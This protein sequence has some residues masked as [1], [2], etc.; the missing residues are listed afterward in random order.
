MNLL[1]KRATEH[2]AHAIA[3]VSCLSWQSAYKDIIPPAELARHTNTEARTRLFERLISSGV[4]NFLL[5]LDDTIPCGMCSY[6]S[7]RDADMTGWGEIVAIYTTEAYWGKGV[8]RAL[9]NAAIAGLRKLGF[10]RV[11]LW[12]FEANA[13]ARRFYEKCEF[14]FDGTV[15]DSGI[16]GLPEVRYRLE[17]Q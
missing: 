10:N 5:A 13:R 14:K 11:M 15:K 17:L 8:G 6:I 4:D 1:I 9:M 12:T 3:Q 2:D 7:S 16:C